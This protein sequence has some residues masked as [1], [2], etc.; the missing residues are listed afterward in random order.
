MISVHQIVWC[1]VSSYR[2][3]SNYLAVRDCNYSMLASRSTTFFLQIVLVTLLP[4]SLG[5]SVACIQQEALTPR[6]RNHKCG[7]T[8]INQSK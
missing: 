7:R 2:T 6:L 1:T 4:K 8:H 5:Y 3:C